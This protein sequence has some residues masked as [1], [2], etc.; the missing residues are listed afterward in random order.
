[1]LRQKSREK[2]LLTNFKSDR[3]ILSIVAYVK[4]YYLEMYSA[5][6]FAE[7]YDFHKKIYGF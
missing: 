7:F 6:P 2:I 3:N 5:N 4:K 1:M